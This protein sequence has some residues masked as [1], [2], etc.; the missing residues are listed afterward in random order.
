M[1]PLPRSSL[2]ALAAACLVAGGSAQ[3]DGNKNNGIN[4]RANL[5]GAQE[6]GAPPIPGLIKRA[7]VTANFAKDLS[8]VFVQLKVEGGGN[9][10]AAH[11]HCALAGSNGPVAFGLFSPGPLSYDGTLASGTLTNADFTGADCTGVIGRPV[12]NIAALA[13]AMRDGLIY[14][15]VHT[16]DN[17]PG[18]VRGQ[19]LE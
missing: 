9:V 17:P 13:L 8:S 18:E 4:T 12:S 16:T 19:M 15:N 3:A 11:F 7:N 1:Y 6:A 5:S 14:V 2:A 10:V